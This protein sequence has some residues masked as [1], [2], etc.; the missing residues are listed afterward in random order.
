MHLSG[1]QPNQIVLPFKK[2]QICHLN[3]HNESWQIAI[4]N[5]YGIIDNHYPRNKLFQFLQKTN[6]IL[7]KKLR[8]EPIPQGITVF[9][10]GS[11][12]GK[13]AIVS[14][15]ECQLIHTNCNSAQK[16]E[17]VAVLTALQTYS[18]PLNIVSDSAYVVHMA[19][20]I[21]TASLSI[22]SNQSLQILF[23]QLQQV[24]RNRQHP[25]FI[26]HIRA[27]T[28]LPGPLTRGNA[29]ADSLVGNAQIDEATHFHSL[30]HIN[31]GGL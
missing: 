10:D 2:Q 19:Q 22:N 24:V 5:F 4:G 16:A 11:N 31:V 8:Q 1:Q 14:E 30:T 27:H 28:T 18:E 25:F 15:K 3:I 6:W 29:I 13:A 23:S 20:N 26:T 9:T 7:P 12:N 21:E 17:L